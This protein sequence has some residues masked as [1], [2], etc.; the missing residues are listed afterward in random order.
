MEE[1]VP[2][3]KRD[4]L[5]QIGSEHRLRSENLPFDIDVWYPAL[6]QFT[7]PSHFLPLR[8]REARALRNY[9]SMV[10]HSKVF[11]MIIH[12]ATRHEMRR[13]RDLNA[14]DVKILKELE[15]RI[16]ATIKNEFSDSGAFCESLI[17]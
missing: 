2:A 12:L 15:E 13:K 3:P 16:D 4:K 9:Y 14:S 7:F 17:C 6:A 1:N 8:R 11:L 10:L 5:L